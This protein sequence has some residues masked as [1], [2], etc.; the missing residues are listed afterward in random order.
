MVQSRITGPGATDFLSRLLPSSLS[1][2]KPYTST[3]SVM[4]N[5][6]GGI[7][8]DC[9]LTRWAEQ[10]YYLVTNAAR[11]KRDLAWI[12]QHLQSFDAQLELLDH[13]G[14]VALQGPKASTILQPLLDHQS[15][16]LDNSLFFGQSIHTEIAGVRVHVA[17]GGYTGEDGFE[18]SIPPDHAQSITSLLLDQPGVTLAGLAARDSLR[19]EAGLCL[20]GTDLDETVS[21]G[22]AGLNWVVGKDRSGFLGE[23]RT[24]KDIG[25]ELQRRRVGLLIE[26]GAPARAGSML[27]SKK[28]P[29]GV[30]TSGIPSPS[31]KN[32]NIAMAYVG[33]HFHNKGTIIKVSVRD[34]LREAKVVKMPFVPARY[35]RAPKPSTEG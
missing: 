10:D 3:L 32:Q 16:K 24:R 20:Y 18:I 26:A 2:L 9:M 17:R 22:E 6:D 8:D 31:L 13:W 21:V 12:Q 5:A 1:S 34:K 27:F 29:I 15:L 23:E 19:L 7:I 11:R 25:P 4:L 14:L 35:H 28:T 33:S 30:V